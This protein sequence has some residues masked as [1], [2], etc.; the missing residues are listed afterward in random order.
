MDSQSNLVVARSWRAILWPLLLALIIGVAFQGTRGLAETSEARYAECAREMLVTGNY[1]EPTLD[2]EPHWT[3]PP[4]TYWAIAGGMQVFG[5]GAWG[6]RMP[7][8]LALLVTV[9]AVG[10]AASRLWGRTAGFAAAGTIVVGYPGLAV[11]MTTSDIFLLAAQAMAGSVFLHAATQADPQQ[12]R[13]LTRGMWALWGLA[14]LVK[15]P[16]ALLPLLAIVPW[17]RM[18]PKERRVPLADPLG[19]LVGAAL[20]LS[21]FLLMVWRHPELLSYFIGTEI[22]DR[23]ASDLGHNRAWYKAFEIYIPAMLGVAGVFGVWAMVCA[24]RHGWSKAVAWRELWKQRDVRLLLVGWIVLPLLVFSVSR[25]K[26]PL[27]VLPLSVPVALLS[28]R[29]LA[30]HATQRSLSRVLGGMALLIVGAKVCAG[31]YP[32][33]RDMERLTQ[34]VRAELAQLPQGAAVILWEQPN[35]HGVSFY[36][37]SR[38]ETLP[39]RVLARS[40]GESSSITPAEFVNRLRH[41]LYPEGAVILASTG[42]IGMRAPEAFLADG[43]GHSLRT[44][45]GW[46]LIRLRAADDAL[47]HAGGAA[48]GSR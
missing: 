36:L 8:V 48:A 17:N 30:R 12:R 18:Q 19:L 45:G 9:A 31:Y 34:E 2:F 39:Q 5:V 16:P 26:L 3:K 7:A 47:S 14:F 27:Y 23:V 22:V 10:L 6:A 11:N 43:S 35:N 4:L 25:S 28:G 15:G 41:G 29:I 32:S 21:W 38:P 46:K 20:G 24:L 42:T 33:D 37:Q 40:D 1:L 13:W 44:V